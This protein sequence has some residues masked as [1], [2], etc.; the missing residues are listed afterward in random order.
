MTIFFPIL[1]SNHALDRCDTGP[2]VGIV[3]KII[4]LRVAKASWKKCIEL[5]RTAIL[6]RRTC[7]LHLEAAVY[8]AME[9][10]RVVAENFEPELLV[11]R[12]GPR[13]DNE[14]TSFSRSANIYKYVK[15]AIATTLS[16]LEIGD[17]SKPTRKR[18]HTPLAKSGVGSRSEAS[19]RG[20]GLG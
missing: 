20:K 13:L 7:S 14:T 3:P 19:V 2:N 1:P 5:D 15:E 16:S 9:A 17:D 10:G 12:S 8:G 4:V 6:V 11:R 18:D